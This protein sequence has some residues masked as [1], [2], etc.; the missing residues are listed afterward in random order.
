MIETCDNFDLAEKPLRP[1]RLGES[2]MQ[3]L[4]CNDA[5]V[6]AV[7]READGGH[8]TPTEL[9]VNG[10]TGSEQLPEALDWED[11]AEIPRSGA[12]RD[13]SSS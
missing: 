13:D 4:Q 7:L 11:Q 2:R 9:A 5:L 3:N 8:S 1:H 10:I 12:V 6:F